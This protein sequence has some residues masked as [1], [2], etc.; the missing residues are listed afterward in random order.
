MG[1]HRSEDVIERSGQIPCTQIG[2]Q[3]LLSVGARRIISCI[4]VGGS[5]SLHFENIAGR[6]KT[7]WG[8]KALLW[9]D[10]TKWRNRIQRSRRIVRKTM[11]SGIHHWWVVW[12]FRF[13]LFVIQH[14]VIFRRNY[15]DRKSKRLREGIVAIEWHRENSSHQPIAR[16]REWAISRRQRR[17]SW[18]QIQSRFGNDWT[19]TYEVRIRFYR[20]LWIWQKK[21]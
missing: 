8:T 6:W 3:R 12:N 19:V 7:E 13:D 10:H 1:S 14:F 21:N 5:I 18:S 16:R 17:W 2:K 20:S 15:F 11:W 9:H 4:A